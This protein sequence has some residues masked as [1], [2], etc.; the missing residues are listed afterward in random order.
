MRFDPTRCLHCG[1]PGKSGYYP[2]K[3]TGFWFCGRHCQADHWD[4]F[5]DKEWKNNPD[6][7]AL[8]KIYT[9]RIKAEWRR[10]EEE[11]SEKRRAQE[12]KEQL[13]Q[14]KEE[15]RERLV[16]YKEEEKARQL[17]K[18]QEEKERLEQKKEDARIAEEEAREEAE[19]IAQEEEEERL[20]E[21][22]IPEKIRLE[23]TLVLGASGSGKTTLLQNLILKDYFE[24]KNLSY[25][26][27]DPKGLMVERLAQIKELAQNVV[28][29]D[30]SDAPALNL[31]T[32][33]GRDPSQLISD[34][35]Y[36]FSTTKQKLT[37][38]QAACFAFCAR[39]LFNVPHAN[40]ETLLDLLD[41][42]GK[43]PSFQ[44]AITKL[45]DINRRFFEKDYYSKG[46]SSTREEIKSRIYGVAQNETLAKMFNA[47]T[48]KLDIA[49]CIKA[50][51][52]LLVNTNM[53]TLAEARPSA[54]TSSAS[55][56]TRYRRERN[57]TRSTLS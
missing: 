8:S 15:A 19:R 38:K 10:Y 34:F 30:P 2:F 41:D 50:K 52:L 56:K 48:R 32:A 27:I 31:F 57:G 17:R 33:Q 25:I 36:I 13:A 11:E 26:V 23:H 21:K 5:S 14:K 46:F 29:I 7:A 40:L 22:P 16:K 39:L 44:T 37:G 28:I 35:S 20:A 49:W 12:E 43:N 54:A 4:A 9:A 45:S 1:I 18:K 6:T 42:E 53:T 55:C 47:R 24:D 51:K 3:N